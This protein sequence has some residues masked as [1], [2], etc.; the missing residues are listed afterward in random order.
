MRRNPV[1]TSGARCDAPK[2]LQRRRLETMHQDKM[3]CSHQHFF[4]FKNN[5]Y[6][7]DFSQAATPLVLRLR[8]SARPR[9]RVRAAAAASARWSTAP[10][11][12]CRPFP[13]TCRSTPPSCETNSPFFCIWL[14]LFCRLLADNEIT[15]LSADGLFGGLPHLR[16]VDLSRNR[17]TNLE[18]NTFEGCAKLTELSVQF[19]Y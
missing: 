10:G 2:K 14:T 6:I 8:P 7:F 3:K 11:C 13:G 9:W 12:A 15:R 17:L 4:L 18:P 19:F 16:K 5:Q 1:E